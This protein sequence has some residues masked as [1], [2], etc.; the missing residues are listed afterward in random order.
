MLLNLALPLQ[1]LGFGLR[2]FLYVI[3]ACGAC[4]GQRI[5]GFIYNLFNF[6]LFRLQ[7]GFNFSFLF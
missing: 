1:K 5:A 3:V 2:Q 6:F 4:G 7:P